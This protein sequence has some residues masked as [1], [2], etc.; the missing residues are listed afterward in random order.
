ML[1]ILKNAGSTCLIGSAIGGILISC[2]SN[3]Q[4]N[5][6]NRKPNVIVVLA[7]DL[8]YG[9]VSGYGAKAIRTPNIDRL[10]DQ[11]LRFTCGYAS[12]AT[13][14]PSRYA[15]M[16][17]LYPWRNK[18]A[19]ILPGDAPL[20][21]TPDMETL[22]RLFQKA[23]YVTGAV[24]KWHLGLGTGSI[25]WNG[26]IAPGPREIGYDYSYIMAATNDRVPCVYVENNHVDNLDG[27]DPI[28]VSYVQNFEGEPTGKDN[29]GLL[30]M[31]PSHGHDQSIVNGVSRIGFM[32]GGK[33]ALW[34]DETMAEVFS[35]RVKSFIDKQGDQ[36]F[37]L[38][39]GLHQPHVP[40]IPSEN[41]AGESGLGPRGDAI[42][43]ADWCVGELLDYLEA[44][45]LIE[46]TVIIFTSDNGPVVDDGYK[47]DAVEKLGDHKPAGTLRG[48]K[49]SLFDGGTRVP[50]V[51]QWRGAVTPGVSDAMVCQMDFYNSFA[52]FTGQNTD[53]GKDSQDVLDAFLGKS[54]TGR[55]ELVQEA[56]GKL[57]YRQD[58][59]AYI[60]SYEGAAF[61]Q[62]TNT[63]LGNSPEEQLYNLDSNIGETENLAKS[64]PSKL[65]EL[66]KRFEEITRNR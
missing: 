48:G 51:V 46:N 21:I 18:N 26:H 58:E 57:A 40:R 44:K 36:P 2:G 55:T 29:P 63:D 8:G 37:F 15:L 64:N 4:K 19:R 14:T 31:H 47:D 20:I 65:E 12:S 66:K 39:Y 3:A 33:S 38:Y 42:L 32:H 35:S 17:G 52:R 30:K 50:F 60:P 10:I 1:S 61:S 7:D 62:W 28:K 13:S 54:G 24:G 56:Q 27:N 41:F 53:S 5:K 25:D 22:P 23:G 43:E 11:G 49:Y 6:P 34:V 45:G 59:W 9:D 16:T